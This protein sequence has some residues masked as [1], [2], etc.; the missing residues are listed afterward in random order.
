MKAES[1]HYTSF[2]YNPRK[3]FA[4]EYNDNVVTEVRTAEKIAG[5]LRR[6]EGTEDS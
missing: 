4:A 6:N 5:F 2:V 1:G 3:K